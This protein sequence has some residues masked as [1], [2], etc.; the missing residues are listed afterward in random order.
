MNR[1]PCFQKKEIASDPA[2]AMVGCRWAG[3]QPYKDT[4]AVSVGWGGTKCGQK[5]GPA[6]KKSVFFDLYLQRDCLLSMP[7]VHLKSLF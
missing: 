7:W 6:K 2:V 5:D 1:C 3:R 4:G